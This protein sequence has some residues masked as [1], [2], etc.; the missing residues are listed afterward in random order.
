MHGATRGGYPW[1]QALLPLLLVIATVVSS[2]SAGQE[3]AAADLHRT[4]REFH[5]LPP[6]NRPVHLAHSFIDP[7]S[8]KVFVDGVLWARDTDYRVRSRSGLIIPLR[9]WTGAAPDGPGGADPAAK[10]LVMV[11]Y[12]FLPVPVT[13]RQDLR[14]VAPA[15]SARA[16]TAA[17]AL[18]QPPA[19]AEAWRAGNLQVSGSKTVQVSSGSR[20]EMTVDQNLRLSISGQLTDEISVRAFLSDDNLPVVPEGNT[21]ELKDIDKV[22]VELTAPNWKAVLGDF[23]AGRRGSTFGNYRRKL[24]GFSLE[25]DPGRTRF[26]LLAGSPRGIYRTLQIRGQESNQGPYY[27]GGSNEAQNLFIIAGS[28]R[29]TLNGQLLTRGSDRDYV[30]DY[31]AGTV[32]F[33]YR[34]LITPE[35]TIVVEFEQ[36]EGPYGRTVLGGGAGSAFKAPGGVDGYVNVRA[37]RERDD[38]SRLRTGEL[39]AEDEA[40]LAAAGDDPLQA[41]AGGVTAAV[42]GEGE[43][44]EQLAGTKVIYVFNESGG[45][46]NLVFFYAGVELG[47]YRLERLTTTGQRVFVHVGDG[48]GSYLIGRPLPR[49]ASQ[50]IVTMT[51]GLGDTT[52]LYVSG[53]WN[54]GDFDANQL[55]SLDNEDNQGQAA[56]LSAGLVNRELSLGGLAVGRLDLTGFWENKDANFR[57]FQVRKTVFSYDAWGLADR[58]RRP[59]FLEQRD[60]EAGAQAAWALGGPGRSLLVKGNYGQLRHGGSI[61]ADQIAAAA[62]WK[63]A[64]GSGKH[65]LQS[66][67]SRDTAD[68]LDVERRLGRHG[69]NWRLG[70]VVPS[71]HYHE[72]QWTDRAI[73]GGSAG[74]FRLEEWGWG[75][76]SAPGRA[77]AWQVEFERGL[78]DSL[79][80][81]QWVLERDS[82]TTKANVTTGRFGGMRLVGE[83]THRQ[84]FA[85]N[86]AEEVTRLARLNLGGV[87]DRSA[88]DWSVGYL[89]D[90]SR[91][92]VLDRQIIFVGEGLGDYNEDG[93]Y[94]GPGQGDHTLALAAT[95]SLVAT[96]AVEA[97]LNWRQGFKFLGADR[98]YGAWTSLAL[99]N[100][101]SRSTT[102]DIGGLL[103]LDPAVLFDRATVVLGDLRYSHELTFLQHLR[104]VDLRGKFDFRQTFDR[105]F[106]DNPEDRLSRGFQA[107]GNLN[108]SRR[109][110]V[111]LRW[112]RQDDRRTTAEAALSARRSYSVLTR[113]YELGYNFTPNTDLRLGLLGE[114]ITRGDEVSGVDQKETAV[115][116]TLRARFR[117]T[118]T[119]QTELRLSDVQSDEPAGSIRPWFFAFPGRNVE[120]SVRLAWDPTEFLAVSASWF[121]R[122]KGEGRWQHDVRLETTAR[123]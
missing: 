8:V 64:G 14:V 40:I 42:P 97:D 84:T 62:D 113:R 43:Y 111:K 93:D 36:G 54:A 46:F 6:G 19:Q 110:A 100:V 16:R 96:T 104:T 75:L 114:Y 70:P 69:V 109:S 20:R 10:A 32:T 30:V 24:Q 29:V 79:R 33:T 67:K 118:W 92:P 61:E 112:Q 17:G 72:R 22:L 98:W 44:D 34:R 28:E 5:L 94:L 25:A 37:I 90:N 57:P 9:D 1:R 82:R 119:L 68:P 77:L 88:S 59:G 12:R 74:G 41:I 91:A 83:G 89:V 56:R 51:A 65:I 107:N 85:P 55:S 15:P 95:D 18:F 53:E 4:E 117:R 108:L 121:T 81:A 122:K 123:F 102:E 105:Q 11:R 66:A 50:S 103:T 21:E 48:Q 38:P 99:V 47:D 52:A 2:P 115:K 13:P 60:S 71:V 31:V 76:G 106:V 26:E 73:T 78:A 101:E 63:L 80:S 49:P 39:A 7:T 116:P 87:W 3:T 23:V 27:L 35:S 86:G 58:A 120:S 45:D